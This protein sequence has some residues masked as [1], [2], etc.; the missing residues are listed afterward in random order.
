MIGTGPPWSESE[1]LAADRP[2]HHHGQAI[3]YNRLKDRTG[4]PGCPRLSGKQLARSVCGA[5]AILAP[6]NAAHAAPSAV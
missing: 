2:S 5:H 1:R 3:A 6:S 4:L